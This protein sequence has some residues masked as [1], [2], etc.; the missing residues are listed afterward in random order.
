M[1]QRKREKTDRKIKKISRRIERRNIEKIGRHRERNKEK[2][3]LDI[4]NGTDYK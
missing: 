2:K 4:L 3:N 1:R